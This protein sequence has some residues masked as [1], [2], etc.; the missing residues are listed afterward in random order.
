MKRAPKGA[1][2]THSIPLSV[3]CRTSLS[4]CLLTYMGIDGP[5]Y[6]LINVLLIYH[7]PKCNVLNYSWQFFYNSLQRCG[8]TQQSPICNPYSY[9][10]DAFL[11]GTQTNILKYGL[12]QLHMS[13]QPNLWPNIIKFSLHLCVWAGEYSILG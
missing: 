10:R 5:A 2:I 1:H 8:Y 7:D 3:T 6:H 13:P 11:Y 12:N 4:T 9:N